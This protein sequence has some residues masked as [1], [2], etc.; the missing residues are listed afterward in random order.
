MAGCCEKGV[1]GIHYGQ[2]LHTQSPAANNEPL[3]R[4]FNTNKLCADFSML[5]QE[6][7][8]VRSVLTEELL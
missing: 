2:K 3:W 1:A 4:T 5:S 8:Q 6:N 7:V